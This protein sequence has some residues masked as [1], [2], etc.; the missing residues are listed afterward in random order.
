MDSYVTL[1]IQNS[2]HPNRVLG[3]RVFTE[4]YTDSPSEK[5]FKMTHPKQACDTALSRRVQ[6]SEASCVAML[7]TDIQG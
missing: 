4:A 2:P 6:L 7:T 3:L 5:R 1:I